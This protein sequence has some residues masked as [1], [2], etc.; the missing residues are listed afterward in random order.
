MLN[1]TEYLEYSST[2]LSKMDLSVFFLCGVN[3]YR[4]EG[5]SLY[6]ECSAALHRKEAVKSRTNQ[7]NRHYIGD[8]ETENAC[9]RLDFIEGDILRIRLE[10]GE[11]VRE[12]ERA[13]LVGA[14][15]GAD[16][17]KVQDSGEA[18]I[19]SCGK[20]VVQID[21]NPFHM[22]V[23]TMDG[24]V[25]YDQYTDDMHSVTS[26]IRRM[27]SNEFVEDE[28][29]HNMP[30]RYAAFEV[31][32]F[33]YVIDNKT[34]EICYT[35]ALR[36]NYREAFFG[37]GESFSS[38]NKSGQRKL[39]WM[40][41]PLGTSSAKSYKNVPFF[42][43]SAG[44]GLYLNSSRKSVFDMGSYFFKTHTVASFDTQLDLFF[45]PGPDYA[46]ILKGYCDLTGH[47]INVPPK[48]SFGVWMGRNCYRTRG[49]IEEICAELRQR[50]L[51]C[52]VI[53]LDWDY[54]RVETHGFD[55]LFDE[56]RFP[57]PASMI[58]WMRERHYRLSLWQLPY[59]NKNT[60]IYDY[61]REK[62]Y[63][64]RL[65][66]GVDPD[67]E[68]V[69]VL[70]FSNPETVAWYQAQLKNLLQ[71]GAS[72]IKTDFGENADA[73][74]RYRSIDG[75]D[76]HN[77][78]P[79]LYNKAAYEVCEEV[80]GEEAL[81]WGRSAFAGA[82]RYPMYWGGDSDSDYYGLYHSLRGG[83][84]LGL[85]GFPFWSHDVGGYFGTPDP[86]VYIRWVQFGM[87]SSHV[88][89]HGTTARE[90][91]HYGDAAVD[92][93]R[94]YAAIRYSLIEYLY[95]EAHHAVEACTPM[96]RHL[97]LDFGGD[98]TVL[99]IDDQYML[100]RNVLVAGVFDN[101]PVRRLYL[102]AGRWLDW[103]TNEIL[104]GSRWIDYPVPPE[105][106]P[107]FLRFGTATPLVAPKNYVGE[108]PDEYIRW[109][110]L[111]DGRPIKAEV[112]GG[113]GPICLSV[114]PNA[115]G[116][117][118]SIVNGGALQ[119]ILEIHG[120]NAPRAIAGGEV[121]HYDAE[122]KILTVLAGAEQ[123]VDIIL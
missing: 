121:R 7:L 106:M 65:P 77:L 57:D 1:A 48:W 61:C 54:T 36:S 117:S 24:A 66:E 28:A 44:Y 102:P 83:L 120:V 116:L 71:M 81:I 31:Y 93:Y 79:L 51:P 97:A 122:A 27:Q 98:P 45:I 38:A 43:S 49:E 72:V 113:D 2:F 69:G 70:D 37:F 9:L 86:D 94:R 19:A 105:I 4:L 108:K 35:E 88:R 25:L 3:G 46:S 63:F 85:T 95:A 14:P 110:I 109:K 68:N 41:N 73:E 55:F 123:T 96:M 58:R 67:S 91:W 47:C 59:L 115:S 23:G 84:S 75:A 100:G 99:N 80:C 103:H 12:L 33:G 89:F 32:P 20:L 104:E 21:K 74:Y 40:I 17:A 30:K 62:G 111:P 82:Q 119:H 10:R 8:G 87:L 53:H 56:Q 92:V 50:E 60:P 101:N 39:I 16:G 6:L 15:K 52:D 76:M 29:F 5:S 13:M 34:G 22:K 42:M 11:A 90:P 114:G 112:M 26:D 107:I 118:V 18:I 78:Y 64:A